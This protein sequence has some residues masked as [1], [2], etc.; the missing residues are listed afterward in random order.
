MRYLLSFCLI[1]LTLSAAAAEH[2][3]I[4]P[5]P[6]KLRYGTSQ[7]GLNDVS[8]GFVSTPSNE[9]LFAAGEILPP[10][11]SLFQ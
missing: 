2:N 7:F 4:I 1:L 10:L 9:D 11:E 5:Q 6:Q 8:I 3:P